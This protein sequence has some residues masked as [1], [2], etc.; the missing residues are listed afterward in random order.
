MSTLQSS[1]CSMGI[2][3]TTETS[4]VNAKT[5][6][7]SPHC[8][9]RGYPPYGPFKTASPSTCGIYSKTPGRTWVHSKLSTVCSCTFPTN[10]VFKV[11]GGFSKPK[12]KPPQGQDK[13]DLV[14]LSTAIR[15]PSNFSK[16]IAKIP[17]PPILLYSG[18]FSSSPPLS[19]P[20]G[21]K[22]CNTKILEIVRGPSHLRLRGT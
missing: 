8:V 16:G 11:P 21:R 9:S 22:E 2:H 10:G 6:R 5:E 18:S 4:T 20:P 17:G 12:S 1:Q 3:Q 7:N 15:Q 13:K 19:V 14:K